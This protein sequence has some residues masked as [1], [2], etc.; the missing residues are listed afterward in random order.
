MLRKIGVVVFYRFFVSFVLGMCKDVGI[1]W[2]YVK[3][4][5]FISEK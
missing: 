4:L 5:V 1:M 2:V 3:K